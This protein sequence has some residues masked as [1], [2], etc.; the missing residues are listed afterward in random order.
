MN[1]IVIRNEQGEAETAICPIRDAKG[2]SLTPRVSI[3]ARDLISLPGNLTQNLGDHN[4]ECM[5]IWGRYSR[6]SYFPHL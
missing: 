1:F 2:M 4:T 5:R 6:V 3:S